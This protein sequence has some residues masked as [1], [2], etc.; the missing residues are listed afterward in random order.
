MRFTLS[1]AAAVL[2]LARP[3]AAIRPTDGT[4]WFGNGYDPGV[5]VGSVDSPGGHFR[6]FY[7]ESSADAVQ[8]GDADMNGIPDFAKA[9]AVH[10]DEVWADTIDARGF[11][12]TLDDSV[13]H[14]S[15]DFG[16]DGRYDI[17]LLNITDSDGYRVIEAC[18]AVPYH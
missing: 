11:R 2:L 14:D 7:V 9:V 13:Y 18:T 1:V 15:A 8:P 3:A 12:P 5:P 17:Y 16:G 6:V 4:G 10:A